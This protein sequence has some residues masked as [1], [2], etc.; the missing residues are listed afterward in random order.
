MDWINILIFAALL[1]IAY[2][3]QRTYALLH[4]W[5]TFWQRA[6]RDPLG[7]A[8]KDDAHEMWSAVRSQMVANR[9][10]SK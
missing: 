7:K 3:M 8:S 5:Y 2:L 1:F 4:E 6:N 9:D 10:K